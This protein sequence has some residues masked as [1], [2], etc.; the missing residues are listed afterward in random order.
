MKVQAEYTRQS[1]LT[2][3]DPCIEEGRVCVF[4]SQVDAQGWLVFEIIL[5]HVK[6]RVWGALIM[7]IGSKN[8]NMGMTMPLEE[9]CR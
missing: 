1:L 3:D 9:Q 5:R 4:L 2:G 6:E 7:L 8:V